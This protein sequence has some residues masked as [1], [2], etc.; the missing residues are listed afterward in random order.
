MT[1]NKLTAAQIDQMREKFHGGIG[2][3]EIGRNAPLWLQ[4]MD[5]WAALREERDAL[6][7][8]LQTLLGYEWVMSRSWSTP[9]DWQKRDAAIIEAER[10]LGKQGE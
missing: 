5:E 8:A 6:R 4:L 2:C 1:E 9:E 3:D 7:Q 10:V